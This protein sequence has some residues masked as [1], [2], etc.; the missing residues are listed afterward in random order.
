M[1]FASRWML[2]VVTGWLVLD[3]TDSA[4]MV[5]L[6]GSLQWLPM[7]VIGTF[8]GVIADRFNRRLVLIASQMVQSSSCL[9]LGWLVVAGSVQ[10][11]HIMSVAVLIGFGWAFD[12]PTRRAIMPDLVGTENVRTAIALDMSAMTLMTAV[13][14][15]AGGELIQA[16]GMGNCFFVIGSL[17]ILAGLF[18][19]LVG[20]VSQARFSGGNGILTSVAEGLSY[21][22][23]HRAILTVMLITVVINV[24]VV[25][26]RHLLPIFAR[27]ILDVGPDGLG[28]LTGMSGMGAFVG[29]VTLASL[30]TVRRPG[31]L[32]LVGSFGFSA[33]LLAFAP[34]TVYQL[35][36]GILFA[37]G[38]C[39]SMFGTLQST[40]LLNLTGDEMRGRVMGVLSFCIGIMPVG[41]LASGALADAIGAPLTVGISAG[42]ASAI[43]L[44]IFFVMP[45]LRRTEY[46]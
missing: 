40:I 38:F 45:S 27:D 17:F 5:A 20:N 23:R 10:V 21:V 36:L 7:L 29:S 8:V 42:V 9:L 37:N 19:Y 3:L 24:F 12:F 28:Y 41:I 14:A 13:G 30:R 22:L 43:V 18:L 2:V 4:F 34:S 44:V 25:P 46:S 15:I 31:A 16:I 33:L 11:W 6:A 1:V 32:F 35:S 39:L 26:F